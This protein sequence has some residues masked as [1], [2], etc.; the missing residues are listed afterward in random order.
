MEGSLTAPPKTPASSEPSA[1]RSRSPSGGDPDP[2]L[3]SSA[4][5]ARPLAYI[6][7]VLLAFIIFVLDL[8]LPLEAT[9]TFGYLVAIML[10]LWTNR[11]KFVVGLAT[12]CCVL[13]WID[14]WASAQATPKWVFLLDNLFA[15]V[16]IW[17]VTGLGLLRLR[18]EQQLA[19]KARELARS[20][21]ELEQFAT[22][23]SHDLCSPLSSLSSCV[24]LLKCQCGACTHPEPRETLACMQSSVSHMGRMI[25][26][27]LEYS[28][29]GR[30]GI[31]KA[32][33][34]VQVALRR[35]LD[36]IRATLDKSGAT[37]T[38]D[39]LPVVRADEVLL[40]Q[41]LQNLIENAIKYRGAAPPRVHIH[42]NASPG[43]WIIS[44]QD[45]GIGIDPAQ[46]EK[47]FQV[48]HRLHSDES[49]YAGLGMGL[50]TCKKIVDRHGGRIWV[51]S[52]AG[53][54]ATFHVALPR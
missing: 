42:V 14:V 9:I 24:E 21:A 8:L 32:Q 35:V 38:H 26:C 34:D 37:V 7:P 54:G 46:S 31:K 17:L 5:P 51:E 36:N 49:K 18:S 45:N 50:A 30:G 33:C 19:Q 16:M 41:L 44:V 43:E 6:L 3:D 20:N 47:I 53:Q 27:I 22:V 48:F 2:H 52:Q 13:T 12:L 1:S 15:I 11:P 39:P 4:E 25:R 40:G 29:V 10:S 23:V 28:R